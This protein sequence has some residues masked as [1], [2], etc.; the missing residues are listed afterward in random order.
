MASRL[1]RHR[2]RRGANALAVALALTAVGGFCALA[3][4]SAYV[5]LVRSELRG[6]ADA[7][8]HAALLTLDGTDEGLV[9]ARA[10]AHAVVDGLSVNGRQYQLADEDIEFGYIDST[11]LEWV[12]TDDPAKAIS[13]RVTP[14]E[15]VGLGLGEVFFGR[16]MLVRTCGAIAAGDGMAGD[17]TEGGP[18]LANGHFDW[19][20]SVG[21]LQCSGSTRCSGRFKHT[22]EFDDV[23]DVTAVDALA[24]VGGHARPA[25]YISPS[26]PFKILVVNA[27]L[28]PGVWLTVNGQDFDGTEWDDVSLAAQT[29]Y[30]LGGVAGTTRLDSL[31]VNYDPDS[32]AN[33]ELLPN[34]PKAV[35]DNA[36]GIEGEWRAGALTVQLVAASAVQKGGTS[37]GDHDAVPSQ[38][39]GLLWETSSFWHWGGPSYTQ[40]TAAEWQEAFDQLP[41]QR[42]TFLDA[43]SMGS[44]C[45]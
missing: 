37:N 36:L 16:R 22:H 12:T 41:C 32:I 40:A 44:V 29:T 45:P 26:T 23:Y 38:A 2:P 7:A 27:D 3:I 11:T 35:S 19:D 33:C 28:S 1:S 43:V 10:A 5:Y 13:V 42:P 20:T 14:E 4:E 31:W 17:G 24:G 18:G 15:W 25:T 21:A 8:G 30:S 39:Q 34:I 9:E 6:V